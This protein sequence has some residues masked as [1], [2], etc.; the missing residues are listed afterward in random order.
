MEKPIYS[1]FEVGQ[2]CQ[3]AL[4]TVIQWINAGEL[5]AFKTPG[6]H[7]RVKQEDLIAF[8]KKHNMPALAQFGEGSDI[9]KV[10][11]VDDDALTVKLL[12]LAIEK[13]SDK[14]EISVAKNGFEAGELVVT[15]KPDLV[16]LD[17]FL[18]GIDGF[19]VCKNIKS[20]ELTKSAKIIAITAY[21]KQDVK[22]K[23]LACGVDEY[24]EKPLDMKVFMEK[25]V[26]ALQ[27]ETK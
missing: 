8:L 9:K 25:V 1:T 19:E 14:I 27:I 26:K 2:I 22:N 6:G 17:V 12:S 13:L 24:L 23:I 16:I 10:A 3:V 20:N 21:P 11:I 5:P 15:N 4:S 7:R 18:P